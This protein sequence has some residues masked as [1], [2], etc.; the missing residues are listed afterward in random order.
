MCACQFCT[1]VLSHRFCDSSVTYVG[2]LLLKESKG[3]F[4]FTVFNLLFWQMWAS[5]LFFRHTMSNSFSFSQILFLEA[6]QK[7][8]S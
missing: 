3:S 2:E 1:F 4:M 8:V 7:K 6:N 5:L